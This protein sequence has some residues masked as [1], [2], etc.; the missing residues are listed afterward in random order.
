MHA[1][2]PPPP[3][4]PHD[5]MIPPSLSF[6]MADGFV[7]PAR[8]WLPPPGVHWRGVILALHGFTDSRDAW[9]LSAPAFAAAGYAVYAPDQR[10]FGATADR[11]DWAG[12][13]RMVDD[14]AEL[15]AQLR[16]RHPGLAVT[17]MGESMGGAVALL[18]A[19]RPAASADNF[20][21]LAPAVWGWHELGPTLSAALTVANLLAPQWAPDPGRIAENI[22][23]S[24]NIA[25]LI[26]LGRDPLTIRAPRVLSTY[27]LVNLMTEAQQA[28]PSV[29]GHVLICSGRRDQLVPPY[30]AA[31]LWGRLPPDVRRAFYPHGYHLLLRDTDRAL[32][33]TDILTWLA[34]P[35]AWLPS[36]ADAATAA[37][38]ADH[39]WTQGPSPLTPAT[40]LDTTGARPIW[41]Y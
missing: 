15:T 39:A 20:V 10:G 38:Q 3:E 9:E 13:T 37:W 11:G 24:D 14:A 5:A 40:T 31:D 36:A 26:R 25:A 17:V 1:L 23:A 33:I 6:T 29:H 34:A 7:L 27:G 2:R 41:P 30:A 21:L 18:L 35:D 4:G 22:Y 12:T 16:A 8:A 19:A 32:V 28:A